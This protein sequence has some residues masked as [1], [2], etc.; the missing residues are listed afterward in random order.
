LDQQGKGL[1]S[2]FFSEDKEPKDFYVRLAHHA[3]SGRQRGTRGEIKVFCFFFSKKKSS[4]L[5]Y[6]CPVAA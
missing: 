2:V 6:C 5:A 4:L 1:G 3:G